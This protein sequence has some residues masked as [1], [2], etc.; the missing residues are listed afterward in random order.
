MRP[1]F[2]R[3]VCACLAVLSISP[4]TGRALTLDNIVLPAGFKIEVFAEQVPNA[5][6]LALGPNGVVFVGSREAGAVYRVRDDDGD[7]FD[8][9]FRQEQSG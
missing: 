1:I 3:L 8:I 5:R 7:F 6:Q 4:L 2:F 9:R